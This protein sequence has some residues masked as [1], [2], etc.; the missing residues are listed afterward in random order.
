MY[1]IVYSLNIVCVRVCVCVCACV[2]VWGGVCLRGFSILGYH[3]HIIETVGEVHI[4]YLG[5]SIRR[6]F[7]A[8]HIDEN[9]RA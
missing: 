3:M 6:R 1:V 2:C 9:L 7:R 4:A 8:T 5:E